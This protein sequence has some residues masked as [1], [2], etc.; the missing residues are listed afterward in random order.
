MKK[1]HDADKLLYLRYQK[2]TCAVSDKNNSSRCFI[3]ITLFHQ[4]ACIVALRI[5]LRSRIL[6]HVYEMNPLVHG[7]A[8]EIMIVAV[9]H[10]SDTVNI[11]QEEI[12]QPYDPSF[13]TSLGFESVAI[14]SV[15]RNDT[16]SSTLLARE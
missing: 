4:P 3:L 15:D 1:K 7:T 9:R 14:K 16:N 11:V 13:V 12:L 5:Y 6:Q 8:D 10:D 2:A